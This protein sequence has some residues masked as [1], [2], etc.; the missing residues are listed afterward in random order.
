MALQQSSKLES[1]MMMMMMMIMMMMQM[2]ISGS[3]TYY[4][5]H[6]TRVADPILAHLRTRFKICSSDLIYPNISCPNCVYE[7]FYVG[8]KTDF[9]ECTDMISSSGACAIESTYCICCAQLLYIL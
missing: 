4:Q 2:M 7:V 1:M 6:S 3:Y 5:L 9:L 8:H